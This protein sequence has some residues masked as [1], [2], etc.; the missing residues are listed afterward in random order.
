V[1]Q[2]LTRF[3]DCSYISFWINELGFLREV[4]DA[5][6]VAPLLFNSWVLGIGQSK[7]E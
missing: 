7:S 4:D 1:Q 6:R 2:E 3:L 5:E